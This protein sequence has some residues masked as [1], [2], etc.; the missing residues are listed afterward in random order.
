MKLN[1]HEYYA[2]PLPE[3]WA[4]VLRICTGVT[5]AN[6][7]AVA[8]FTDRDVCM[9]SRQW[10]HVMYVGCVCTSS[11]SGLGLIT[12]A[13]FVRRGSYQETPFFRTTRISAACLIQSWESPNN[14]CYHA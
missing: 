4:E 10:Q 2:Y 1:C 3:L 13:G 8:S 5:P 14:Y 11:I 12:L 7:G 6:V 9:K